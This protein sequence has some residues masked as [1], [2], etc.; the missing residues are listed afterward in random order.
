MTDKSTPWA[1]N[2]LLPGYENRLNEDG[3]LETRAAIPIVEGTKR[4]YCL[5]NLSLDHLDKILSLIDLVPLTIVN[6]DKTLLDLRRKVLDE[7]SISS[8]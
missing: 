1:T 5:D 8:S 7:R 6:R 4:I 2:K 3:H